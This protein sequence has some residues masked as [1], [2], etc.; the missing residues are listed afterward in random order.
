MTKLIGNA[1]FWDNGAKQPLCLRFYL[2]S[3]DIRI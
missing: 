2:A 3:C 1:R